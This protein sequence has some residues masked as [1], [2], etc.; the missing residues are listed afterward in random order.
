M[1][2]AIIGLL[3]AL[4][5]PAVQSARESARRTACNNNLKQIG[6]GFLSHEQSQG[7]FPDGGEQYWSLRSMP[8]GS[9]AA[10]PNQNWGWG[11]QLLPYL[12]QLTVWN[13]ASDLSVLKTP[14]PVYFCSSRRAP[15][16]ITGWSPFGTD[17]RAMNDYA[18]N[19]GTDTT[20]NNGW[21]MMGN[22]KD[23][24][25]V[26]R[27][28]GNPS[29]SG[30]VRFATIRDGTT[31][32]LLAGEKT[33]NCGRLGE[34]QAE[35]DGGYV[36][37][38]DFDTIRWGYF[39]PIP[40]W[41]DNTDV[42]RYHNNYTRVADRSAFG[43]AHAAAFGCVFADGSVRS[44]DYNVSPTVFM[45]LSSRNDGQVVNAGDF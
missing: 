12:E 33:Y 31:M 35:D 8:G 20:G 32:T 24:T 3:V 43:S 30:P 15:Q 13:T 19:G 45:R 25:V 44:T 7:W 37:G 16:V 11:Y 17:T 1:V 18:G 28:N 21:G 26:R 27:P 23:G 39:P 4:M 14:I 6:L 9:P 2:V 34:R 5:L 38:W 42:T 10:S 22:G 36:E 41:F 40:D 29:R